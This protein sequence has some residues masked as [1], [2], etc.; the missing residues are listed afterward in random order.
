MRAS[1]SKRRMRSGSATWMRQDLDGHRAV[2]TGIAGAIDLAHSALA[3]VGLTSYGPNFCRLATVMTTA[4]IIAEGGY[5]PG[6]IRQ[7][8]FA[9]TTRAESMP[10]FD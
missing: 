7:S 10:W 8:R 9:S 1:C 3:Y 4:R 5:G 6:T 2:Q